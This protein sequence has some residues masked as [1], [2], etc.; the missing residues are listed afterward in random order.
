MEYLMIAVWTMVLGAVGLNVIQF[1]LEGD[2]MKK[3][4]KKQPPKMGL[5]DRLLT[6]MVIKHPGFA[7]TA[8][9]H[10]TLH[11]VASM[12]PKPVVKSRVVTIA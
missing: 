3:T 11:M 12:T 4:T 5:M 10:S 6:Y 9:G 1:A 8:I 7:H 2:M